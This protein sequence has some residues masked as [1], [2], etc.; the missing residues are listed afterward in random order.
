MHTNPRAHRRPAIPTCVHGDERAARSI[1]YTS[2]A[3][4]RAAHTYCRAHCYAGRDAD[5]CRAAL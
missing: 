5:R 4:R 2:A 3:Q 1:A